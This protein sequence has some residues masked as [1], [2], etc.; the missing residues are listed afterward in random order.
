MNIIRSRWLNDRTFFFLVLIIS[1]PILLI[2]LGDVPFIEDEGIR[3]LVALEMEHSGKYITPTLYGEYYYKKPP[4]WNWILVASYRITGIANEFTTRLPVIL[5]LFL[6]TVS[7]F[8]CYK[9]YLGT[10][11]ATLT[12][13]FSL[14]CGRILFWDSMLGLIDIAFSGIIFLFFFWV[15]HFQ[16]KQK[17]LTLYLGAYLLIAMAF[18]L[19]A[20][21]AIVFLCLT[22]LFSHYYF[23]S[24]KNLFRW[25]HWAGFSAFL[26]ITGGYL[27]AFSRSQPVERLLEVFLSESTRRTVIKH[28]ILDSILQII[29]FPFE[30]IYHFLPWSVL[31]VA[32]LHKDVR[33][34][35]ES[36]P[37]IRFM[38]LVFLVNIWIYWSS[39]EVYPRY[40]L[41]F[42]PLYLGGCLFAYDHI[43]GTRTRKIT[44]GLLILIAGSVLLGSMVVLFNQHTK[45]IPGIIWKWAMVAIPMAL[46]VV[47][48]FR[49]HQLL[50][51]AFVVFLI[52][53][54][55]GFS[56]IVLPSRAEYSKGAFT[57]T[58]SYR[59][60]E[61]T[62][63]HNLYLLN[64]DTLRYEVGF[65]LTSQRGE[66][67]H[68]T[69]DLQEDAYMLT[70]HANYSTLPPEYRVVDSIRVRRK[71]SYV[72]LVKGPMIGK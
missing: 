35:F 9:T 17:T 31:S 53:A 33:R 26:T 68:T 22:M 30:M 51:H 12:A 58:D 5:F 62:Y 16:V 64:H 40:L 6:F 67:L 19:K 71:E 15:Y 42:I 59:V 28:G 57:R 65:Y 41:M 36:N 52:A 8:Y 27:Y 56:V 11:F 14:T 1:A 55:L 44:D 60:A 29:S 39:P 69:E 37:F 7:I 23:K 66:P 3:G 25:Q 49:H 48:M 54:R 21:P 46:S 24:W 50:L 45:E 47:I 18:L 34:V 43:R 10:R 13:L 38:A 32:L 63:G 2:N 72:Y 61:S 20:L 4:L 70:N